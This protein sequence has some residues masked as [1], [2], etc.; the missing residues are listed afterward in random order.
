MEIEERISKGIPQAFGEKPAAGIPERIDGEM[1]L[2]KEQNLEILFSAVVRLCG[3]S[4]ENGYPVQVRGQ[5]GNLAIAYLAG[6]V[7]DNPL[8]Y[9]LTPEG[10]FGIEGNKPELFELGIAE[11][12]HHGI[13]RR[14]KELLPEEKDNRDSSHVCAAINLPSTSQVSLIGKLRSL[15]GKDWK[16]IDV[17]DELLVSAACTGN[18]E[19]I[20]ELDNERFK[21]LVDAIQP[22][23]FRELLKVFSLQHDTCAWEENQKKYFING[24]ITAE[25]MISD[26]E[27]VYELCMAAGMDAHQAFD[28][29][30]TVRRGRELSTEQ[31][32]LLHEY[33]APDWFISCTT[34]P[35]RILYLFP[36]AHCVNVMRWS[37]VTLWYKL[38]YPE[39]FIRAFEETERNI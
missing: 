5:L 1:K 24:E 16:D 37:L 39:E 14:F 34:G 32:Y 3:Y 26:R 17:E 35:G 20:S 25:T 36:R 10:F 27:D 13:R 19:G 38:H 29:R 21:N 2:L 12:L 4:V 33:H 23:T 28:V 7:P 18:A 8:A 6:I 11:E 31:I 22:K 30:E 15:T 9:R